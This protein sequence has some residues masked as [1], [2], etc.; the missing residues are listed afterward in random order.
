MSEGMTIK[1]NTSH[2]FLEIRA[3][4]GCAREYTW[5]GKSLKTN[6]IPR[7]ERWYGQLGLI[8]GNMKIPF[9]NVVIMNI[10][11]HQANYNSYEPF[12]KYRNNG[13]DSD[14]YEVYNDEGLLLKFIKRV[15]PSDQIALDILVGQIL[16]NGHKPSKLL[17]SRNSD[18]LVS[19]E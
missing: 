10:Q 2:G 8:S 11:E 6:L 3:G 13:E 4:E 15:S 17:G 5:S 14:V 7:T 9:P 12:L 18:I 1:A 16:I 19:F